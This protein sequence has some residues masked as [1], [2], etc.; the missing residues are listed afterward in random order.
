MKLS[1]L[2]V[3]QAAAH[4]VVSTDDPDAALLPDYLDAARS[5]VLGYTGLPPEEADA[6]PEL[7]VAALVVFAE[8]VKNK[9]LT[10][11]EDRVSPVLES[12]LGMH[13]VNLL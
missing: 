9:E 1:E 10:V 5:Y 8:L 7:A 11:D 12:F 3:E 13:S 4:A 6:K 2:T